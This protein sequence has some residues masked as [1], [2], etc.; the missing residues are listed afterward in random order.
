[1]IMIIFTRS[2]ITRIEKKIHLNNFIQIYMQ[3]CEPNIYSI[4]QKKNHFG[5]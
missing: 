3:K 1:M 5:Q 4:I 2:H